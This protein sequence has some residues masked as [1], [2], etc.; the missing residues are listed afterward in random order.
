MNAL[1]AE[2]ATTT[3][4]ALTAHLKKWEFSVTAVDD[5][6]KAFECL[7]SAEEALLVLLDW[8]MP[9]M[10][11][12]EVCERIRALADT[13]PHY[14]IMLTGRSEVDDVVAGLD[15]GAN[16][17]IQKPFH[18]AELRARVEVGSRML[19]LEAALASRVEELEKALAEVKTLSGLIPMCAGCKKI[20][21]DTG[22]WDEVE[23]YMMRHS[24]MTF[25]HGLC[26]DCIVKHYPDYAD[27]LNKMH[28]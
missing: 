12:P 3:M 10:S 19:V 26:P 1:I 5:G 22:Y 4:L 25:S 20:R 27:Q 2:D 18:P 16:D 21:N 15:A 6:V 17:Y 14:V 28:S 9:E 11:G 24:D 13:P 7:K 23:A 8:E